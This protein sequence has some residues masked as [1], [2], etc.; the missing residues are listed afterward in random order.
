MVFIIGLPIFF[1]ELFVGQYSG[2]GPIKAYSFLA[3]LF[4]GYLRYREIDRKYFLDLIMFL[5][6]SFIRS[7]LLHASRYHI[8]FNLLHGDNC[9]GSLLSI[10]IVFP[11]TDLGFMR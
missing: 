3:P 9:L 7:G 5:S 6:L 4:K 8:R 10:H 1:A 11:I 2:L